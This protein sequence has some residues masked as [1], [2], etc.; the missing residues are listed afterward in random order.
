MGRFTLISEDAFDELQLDAGV[1]LNTFDPA[2][3][4]RPAS[5]NIIATTSG[6]IN[7]T[8]TPTYSDFGDD[9]DNVPANMMEFKH[10]DSWE[11]KFTFTSLKFNSANTKFA[12][13]AADS[14]AVTADHYTKIVPRRDLKQSDFTDT[15]WW[16]G[17]K[18]N[19]GAYA[20]CLKNAL[21]TG[22]L[23]IQTSKNN[24][25][26]SSME[27]TGHV[28][29]SAQDDMPMEFYEIDTISSSTTV[30]YTA[31]SP[32]GTENPSEEGWYVLSGNRYVLSTDTAV[33]SNK[34]YYEATSST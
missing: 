25:G 27:L 11:C 34:T 1:L 32:V 29:A 4:V 21:S 22:G 7:V 24:K 6:G 3:P 5:A 23:S 8:C 28:S 20:V 15:I 18:A 16:V 30:T 14:T 2:N 31:V 12:L 33:D 13:G 19:G 9:V 10:L 26:T 17:D